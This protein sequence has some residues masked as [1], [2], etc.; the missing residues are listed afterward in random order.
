ML[1]GKSINNTTN[2]RNLEKGK[3]RYIQ[4]SIVSGYIRQNILNLEVPLDVILV[5]TTFYD[6]YFY[7]EF[8][9][10]KLKEL[11]IIKSGQYITKKPFYLHNIKFE[12]S[13]YPNEK[14]DED[15]DFDTGYIYLKPFISSNVE[16]ITAFLHFYCEQNEAEFKITK[17]FS[18]CNSDNENAHIQG[19]SDR[20]KW[21][22]KLPYKQWNNL[23]I[24]SCM[25]ILQIK[26]KNGENYKSHKIENFN[27][28]I[29]ISKKSRLQW[30]IDKDLLIK[31][32]NA[33]HLQ[34]F[35]SEM[36]DE[37]NENYC[38]YMVPQGCSDIDRDLDL[39]TLEIIMVLFKMPHKISC[40]EYKYEITNSYNDSIV[41]GTLQFNG[42]SEYKYWEFN[43][44]NKFL[45]SNLDKIENLTINV[46]ID[47]DAIYDENFDMIP[48]NKWSEYGVIINDIY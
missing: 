30:K 10:E 12:F 2:A 1:R 43:D 41:F 38:V 45:S 47:I 19:I 8:D 3:R 21:I 23:F 5:C 29:K 37:I 48:I 22:F 13:L 17:T 35:I 44:D 28:N 40:I 20:V 39:R 32:R 31:M 9:K 36:F 4:E 11:E 16:S 24:V 42:Y 18:N 15:S 27:K 14:W 6:N 26:Y 46:T 7:W 25:E 33:I 34:C